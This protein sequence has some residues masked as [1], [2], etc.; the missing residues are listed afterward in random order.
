MKH[1]FMSILRNDDAATNGGGEELATV[2]APASE[3]T[4]EVREQ[5]EEAV[6][7]EAVAEEA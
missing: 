5:A 2:P 7:E 4:A 1:N 6:A 3:A